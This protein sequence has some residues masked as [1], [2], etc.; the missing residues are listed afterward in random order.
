MA[1]ASA[2]RRGM[3]EEASSSLED[4]GDNDDDVKCGWSIVKCFPNTASSS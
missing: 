3:E 1:L 2:S 4:N